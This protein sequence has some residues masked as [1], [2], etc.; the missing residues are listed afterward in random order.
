MTQQLIDDSNKRRLPVTGEDPDIESELEKFEAEE[1]ARLGLEA[2]EH[3]LEDMANLAF[4]KS[5]KSKIT[6]LIGG[7]TMAHDY[8]VEG[9]FKHLGYGVVALDC[10]DTDALRVGKEFGNRAQCNPTYFTVG[11][12]VKY[13]IYLRDEKG[14]STADIV[15]KFVF[16]TAGACG[17]CRFG[18]YVTEYR[19]A[20]RDAGFDGFRVMLFQQQGGL[21]QA[22]GEESGLELNPKFFLGLL[23]ALLAGDILNGLGYRIRPFEVE[24]GATDRAIAE[25]KKLCYDALFEGKNILWALFQSQRI[26]G[27]VQVDRLQPK[28]R[29]A[30]I[31]EFWAMT[32][33]GD[34]NYALQR[35]LESEGAECDIQFVTAWILYNIWEVT[36]D[37]RNRA[38]LRG[39]DGG[40]TG[41]KDVGEY[42]VFVRKVGLWA[43]D[44]ALRAA[45]QTFAH[46]GG[47]FEYHLPDMH[48]IA[49]L[50][51]PYYNNDLRGGEGH[52]EVGKLI[53]NV[54]KSKATMTLSV[55][56]FGCMPS[57]SVSD[58]VQ[59][60]IT[61]RYPG[62]I[63]CAVETSGD[64]AVN[65]YSRVQMYLF[66]AKQAAQ[67]EFDKALSDAGVTLDEVRAF[68]AKHPRYARALH[69][70]PHSAA[71]TGAD[72]IHE[73]AQLMTTTRLER[74]ASRVK[75]LVQG[76]RARAVSAVKHAPENAKSAAAL[77]R[78]GAGELYEI[79]R[80]KLPA[81]AT[82]AV[83][84]ARAR[85]ATV[86]PFGRDRNRGLAAAAG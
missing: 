50:A 43:A 61:E 57:S 76:G 47:F 37:T 78:Q 10:P 20:L 81:L 5:E 73:V 21:S 70:A 72:L 49:D 6:L 75:K 22:T 33:E 83:E 80:E 86:L 13:L 79:G 62:T 2:E 82:Q 31:G 24:P 1:R 17:P 65:F 63:F 9:A 11:N 85:A 45:F 68:L 4:T 51:A 54:A 14:M 41:L 30:I 3:W 69:R 53:L 35:F 40:A 38:L 27:K 26:L 36:F 58:G 23:K 59:S 52:M 77:T 67:A 66:K 71:A 18:M 55:K 7:L 42:G 28:P 15:D 56:P 34:G 74:A 84:R 44:K 32:T 19:K 64:G 25:C 60:L 48:Q 46:A 12:L 8:L 29:V 39:A 16:L